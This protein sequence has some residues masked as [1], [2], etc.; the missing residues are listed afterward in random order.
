[1]QIKGA[2]DIVLRLD[3][4]QIKHYKI[5]CFQKALLHNQ[6]FNLHPIFSFEKMDAFATL[7]KYGR[8]QPEFFQVGNLRKSW[9]S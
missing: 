1:M 3:L 6:S 2:F 8:I 7:K 9:V 4:A 5:V